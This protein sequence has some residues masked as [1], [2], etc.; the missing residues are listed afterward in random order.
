MSFE[1]NSKETKIARRSVRI[2]IPV[3]VLSA[4]LSM[5]AS[6]GDWLATAPCLSFGRKPNPHGI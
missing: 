2:E 6:I 1:L 5:V 4:L 3:S